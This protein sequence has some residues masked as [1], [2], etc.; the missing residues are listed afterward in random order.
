MRTVLLFS[1]LLLAAAPAAAQAPAP[2][3]SPAD[4]AATLRLENELRWQ[5]GQLRALEAQTDR[6]RTDQTI[7][8]LQAR[9]RPDARLEARQAELD[10]A[11]TEAL[12]R[13]AQSAST[14]RAA[15]LRASE[16]AYDRRLRDLG[17]ASSLPLGSR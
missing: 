15:R 17:Y 2:A 4:F 16:P 5:A 11:E 13:A 3:Q 9:S 6:L 1:A 10:A 7:R 12:R 14:D 8:R